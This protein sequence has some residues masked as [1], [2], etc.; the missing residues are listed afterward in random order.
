[1]QPVTGNNSSGVNKCKETSSKCVVWDGPDINCLG[2]TLCKGQS[3]EVIVYNTAKQLCDLLEM[4][5]VSTVDLECLQLPAGAQLPQNIIELSQLIINKLCDLNEIV[6]DLQNTGTTPIYVPLPDCDQ[7][8]QNCPANVTTQYTDANGNLVTSLLLI[9]PDGQTSPAVEY[10][11]TLICDLLCRM[12]TAETEIADLRTDVDNIMNQIA[13]ALPNVYMPDCIDGTAGD[14]QIVDPTNSTRGAVPDMAILL[15]EIKEELVNGN[16]VN[17]LTSYA[18][19]P[20]VAAN[21]NTT[22]AA[23]T[24]LGVYPLMSPPPL[25][26]GDLGAITNPQTLQEVIT[27]L[28]VAVC[29]LRNFAAIVKANCCPPYC[30][31]V[32]WQMAAGTID[33]SRN[34]VRIYLNGTLTDYFNN[35]TTVASTVPSPGFDP[36]GPPAFYEGNYPYTVTISDQSGNSVTST[37][38]PIESLF[39]SGNFIDITNLNTTGTP[40]FINPLDNYD[41]T[42]TAYIVAPDFSVCN[43]TLTKTIAAVCDNQ[44]FAS[45]SNLYVGFDGVTIQYV[46]PGGSWPLSGT[47]PETIEIEII[48]VTSSPPVLVD[49]GSIDYANYTGNEIYI[50]SDADNILPNPG[51][52]SGGCVNFFQTDSI[53]PNTTYQIRMRILYNCGASTWTVSPSFTTFVPIEITLKGSAADVCVLGGTFTLA[54][55]GSPVISL[56]FADPINFDPSSDTVVTVFAQ[57]GTQFGYILETPYI[58]DT[59]QSIQGC[60][61]QALSLIHI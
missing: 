3:I 17:T 60:P 12:S 10:M 2:V 14:K 30:N 26:L 16:P 59:Q 28:W 18:L 42:L 54:P 44:P 55:T 1:M 21:C 9:G 56:N 24:P 7:I 40:G 49:S 50:Y 29:D 53:L 47:I 5:N 20:N 4:L 8:I 27:N 43:Q 19:D 57:A 25:D 6:I 41:V 48:D 34:T 38:T 58:V 39:T 13:G 61:V 46:L 32:V 37:F 15:C 51:S 52:C 22:I 23:A 11:A 35:S 36:A 31:S 33:S 45:L